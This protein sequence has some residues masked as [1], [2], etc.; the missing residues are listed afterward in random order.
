VDG[1]FGGERDSVR[2]CQQYGADNGCEDRLI[3]FQ[4]K[5]AYLV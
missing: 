1:D 3:S 4:R 5:S 2:R